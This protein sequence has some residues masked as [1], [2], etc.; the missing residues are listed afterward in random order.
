SLNQANPEH[1]ILM[2]QIYGSLGDTYNALEMHAESNVAYEEALAIDSNNTYVLNNYSYYLALRKEEL[3]KAAS[4]SKKSNELN[5]NNASFQDTYAWILFQQENYDEALTW[6]EK[7]VKLTKDPSSTLL[8]HK[9]DILYKLGNKE[10]AVKLWEKAGD[11]PDSKDNEKL[12][13]KIKEKEYV[14]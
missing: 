10:E 11:L 8:E 3:T 6:I 7:A 9:G 5:P 4:M 2:I 14:D 12:H 1:S 13:K